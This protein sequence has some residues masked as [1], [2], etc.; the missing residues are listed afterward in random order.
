MA[1]TRKFN[2]STNAVGEAIRAALGEAVQPVQPG[3]AA[4]AKA[5][6]PPTP[7]TTTTRTFTFGSK[8]KNE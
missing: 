6:P 2:P 7:I 5:E 4:P 3:S 8:A 1:E